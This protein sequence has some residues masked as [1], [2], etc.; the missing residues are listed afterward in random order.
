VIVQDHSG[1]AH[2][3]ESKLIGF[4]MSFLLGLPEGHDPP[5]VGLAAGDNLFKPSGPCLKRLS[6]LSEVLIPVID[7]AYAGLGMVQH[8]VRNEAGEP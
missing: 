4:H 7:P 6:L 1:F 8:A 5:I 3:D 2:T